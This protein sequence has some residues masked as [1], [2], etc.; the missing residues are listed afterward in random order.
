MTVLPSNLCHWLVAHVLHMIDQL[1]LWPYAGLE[2][3]TCRCGTMQK[4]TDSLLLGLRAQRCH[5]LSTHTRVL[6]ATLTFYVHVCSQS[7]SQ[8]VLKTFSAKCYVSSQEIPCAGQALHCQ[9]YVH[10]QAYH[11]VIH[12]SHD[13]LV[14]LHIPCHAC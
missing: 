8:L 13:P 5:M 12:G 7:N 6:I 4:Q 14:C 10:H 2:E 1:L 3:E 11:P 9:A